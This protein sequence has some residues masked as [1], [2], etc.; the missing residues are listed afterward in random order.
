MDLQEY[1]RKRKFGVTPEPRGD[2]ARRTGRGS[3]LTYAIQ[4]HRAT[5]L[6]YDFRLEW[7]GVLLS[8][9]I[10]KGPSPDPAVKRLAMPVEDHPLEY[11]HF[12]GVIPQGEYGAGTVMLWD[13]G[14]WV[15]DDPDVDA[16]LKKG[17]LKFTLRG[18]KL[19]GSWVLVHTRGFPPGSGRAAWL[20]I[21]HR[22]AYASKEDITVTQPR[23]ALSGKTLRAIAE[24]GGDD[25]QKA[26][27]G[28][29]PHGAGGPRGRT[30]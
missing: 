6:H 21:K 28:D 29:P 27:S 4:K 14:T 12:E 25:V 16:S 3:R 11:A 7:K 13:R 9:A 19:R 23:S 1:R 17:D 5:S 8:W 30:V 24:A 18:K 26:A 15:P 2:P 10:P 20:L 22:D